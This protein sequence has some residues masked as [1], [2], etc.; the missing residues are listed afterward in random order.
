MKTPLLLFISLMCVTLTSYAQNL[1]LVEQKLVKS[2]DTDLP[3]AMQFLK[4]SV[5]INSG[6]FNTAGIKKVGAMYEKELVALGFTIEW[7]PM[8]DSMKRAGHFVATRKGT[9]GKKLFLIGHL[10]TVFEPDTPPNPYTM[11]NDTTVTG[12]GVQDMK[13][14]I[15]ILIAALKAMHKQGVLNDTSMTIYLTGDEENPGQPNSIS[16]ADFIARARQHD[17]A[18][19]FEPT[20]ALDKVTVARRGAAKWILQVE[21]K[22]GHSSLVFETLGY[23]AIYEATRIV[24]EFREK[25]SH[26]KDIT[27]NPGIFIG[28]SEINVNTESQR[29]EASG[30]NNIISPKTTVTGDLRYL[31]EEQRKNAETSMREIVSKNLKATKAT[32]SF[33]ELIPPMAPSPGNEALAKIVSDAS[34]A[35]GYGVVKPDTK[36]GGGDVSFVA[37][38]V[39]S[40]DGLGALGTGAH[41]PGEV[42]YLNAYPKLI[43]KAALILYRLTR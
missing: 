13:G 5:N 7:I 22:Q 1:S 42:I 8:P 37:R 41:A 19:A 9:K 35:L 32:I 23:G 30:K 12:Q 38:Y 31:T 18:L 20:V 39:D 43:K 10:D 27:V 15:V 14:G 6:T 29:G 2:I 4:E 36:L 11:V 17:V 26:E 21:G 28:G 40:L 34:V 3:A 25:F 16:R 33:Q 24:N